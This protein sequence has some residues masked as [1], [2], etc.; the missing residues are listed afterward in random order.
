MITLYAGLIADMYIGDPHYRLHPIRIIGYLITFLLKILSKL[1]AQ[2]VAGY[3]L[4]VLTLIITALAASLIAHI[5]FLPLNIFI[6]YS[7]LS[8]GSLRTEVTKV[9]DADGI[10]AKRQR[11]KW[12]VSRDTDDMDLKKIYT[13]AFETLSENLIDGVLAPMLYYFLLLPFGLEIQAILVYKAVNTLDSMAGYKTPEYIYLGRPSAILDDCVNLIPA[14][15]FS[16][17]II[18]SAAIYYFLRGRFDMAKAS[19]TNGFKVYF[20]DRRKHESPNSAHPM[21]AMAGSLGVQIGGPTK[22]FG[23][24][25]K[26]PFIGSNIRLVDGYIIKEGVYISYITTVISAALLTFLVYIKMEG[27]IG[28]IIV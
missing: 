14:R 23:V 15:V 24:L 5:N 22:Y 26:K 20:R 7:C 13:S 18:L 17:L 4:T 8:L 1:S 28:G 11:L 10:D 9:I 6:V 16:P 25:K 12:I 3:V 19:I 21:S 27:S 2:K